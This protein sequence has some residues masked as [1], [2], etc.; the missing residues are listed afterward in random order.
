[1]KSRYKNQVA[2]R[3]NTWHTCLGQ[4][5]K[6]KLMQFFS[7]NGSKNRIVHFI[8]ESRRLNVYKKM[9]LLH[10]EIKVPGFRNFEE[11]ISFLQSLSHIGC[12]YWFNSSV[13]EKNQHRV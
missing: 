12:K 4:F 3:T 1:M 11:F 5:S 13:M 2:G 10:D 9:L 7:R 6:H 8:Y